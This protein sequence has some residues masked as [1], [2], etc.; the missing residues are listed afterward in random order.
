MRICLII[1]LHLYF[2]PFVK[3]QNSSGSSILG[4]YVQN[5]PDT[6]LLFRGQLLLN[7]DSIFYYESVGKIKDRAA[8]SY[9]L[10]NDTLIFKYFDGYNESSF[11]KYDT[12]SNPFPMVLLGIRL[13]MSGRPLQL[14]WRNNRLLFPSKDKQDELEKNGFYFIR[15]E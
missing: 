11:K 3:S 13:T 9:S 14:L 4:V 15:K 5:N 6:N 12:S 1:F 10:K 8:G 2:L 7:K